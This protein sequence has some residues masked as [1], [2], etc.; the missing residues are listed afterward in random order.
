MF[1]GASTYQL[2]SVCRESRTKSLSTVA[3]VNRK[4][5]TV[6]PVNMNQQK[7]FDRVSF[8]KLLSRGSFDTRLT[9]EM[10]LADK[11]NININKS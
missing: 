3:V 4:N 6:E 9:T 10:S 8:S 11:E 7:A 5:S 2:S 1:R